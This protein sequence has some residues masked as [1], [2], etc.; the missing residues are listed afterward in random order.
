MNATK[1]GTK[2]VLGFVAINIVYMARIRV[3]LLLASALVVFG[4][5]GPRIAS[6][7][8]TYG[9]PGTEVTIHGKRLVSGGQP[10]ATTVLLGTV[11]QPD[12]NATGTEA[13]FRIAPGSVTGLIHIITPNGTAISQEVFEVVDAA[14]DPNG[15]FTFGGVGPVQAVKV[16][17]KDKNQPVLIGI[18]RARWS[19]N[20]GTFATFKPDGDNAF[21]Y[22]NSFWNEATFGKVSFLKQYLGTSVIDLPKSMDYYYHKFKQREI[23]SRGLPTSIN[24]PSAQTLTIASDG[25]GISVTFKRAFEKW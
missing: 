20:T 18:F 15:R 8:P 21:N 3:G 25:Q 13:R 4:C 9:P 23:T 10:N 14:T 6:F 5:V 1:K 19:P 7:A 16:T 12:R 22:M 17:H 11:P 2:L 24:L